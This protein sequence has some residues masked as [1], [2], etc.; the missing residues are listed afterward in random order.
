MHAFTL[1]EKDYKRENVPLKKKFIHEL[2]RLA[3]RTMSD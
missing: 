2:F 3:G 1:M